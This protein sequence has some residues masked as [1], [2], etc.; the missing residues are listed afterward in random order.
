[1]IYSFTITTKQKG[2]AREYLVPSDYSLYDFRRFIENDLDFDDSQQGVFFTLD[3]NN[4]KT[5]CYSLFDTGSGAMDSI[6]LEALVEKN[7][8]KLLYT[9]DLFNNRSL[10]IEL[11][12]QNEPEPRVHYPAVAQRKGNPPGQFAETPVEDELESM[13]I[14]ADT[15]PDDDGEEE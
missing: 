3:E 6:T 15:D 14:D 10:L 5:A 7:T 4:R 8:T 11:L 2:F 13:Q 9:F 1:M 12:D